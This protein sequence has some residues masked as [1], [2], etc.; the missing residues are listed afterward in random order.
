MD[1]N[2]F[3]AEII[4]SGHSRATLA[5]ND[6]AVLCFLEFAAL[7]AG[8]GQTPASEISPEKEFAVR[9][10]VVVEDGTGIGHQVRLFGVLVISLHLLHQKLLGW[11][12]RGFALFLPAA[13]FPVVA[14][15][16]APRSEL[17]FGVLNFFAAF[18]FDIGGS[19]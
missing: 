17:E 7:L 11:L 8:L 18:Q 9:K 10:E 16:V 1:L 19:Q 13:F 12:Y 14:N 6:K 2:C 3:F 4:Q 5:R 15:Q